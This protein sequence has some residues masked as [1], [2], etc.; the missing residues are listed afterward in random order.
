MMEDRKQALSMARMYRLCPPPG[1]EGDAAN[2]D[3]LKRHI[4]ICPYC[5]DL[6]EEDL[7]PWNDLAAAIGDLFFSDHPSGPVVAGR[8]YYLKKALGR[9]RGG[10]YYTP[11]MVMVIDASPQVSE[12]ILVAQIYHD[13]VLAGPGDL[14]LAEKQGIEG[15]LFVEP[16]NIYTLRLSD[17][18]QEV[19][20]VGQDVVQAV[21]DMDENPDAPP[22]WAPVLAPFEQQDVRSYFREMEIEVGYTFSAPAVADLVQ[23]LEQKAPGLAYDDTNSLAADLQAC[24]AGIRWAEEVRTP[25]EMLL[26]MELPPEAVPLAAAD[27]SPQEPGGWAPETL[28]ANIIYLESGRVRK[29]LA[30]ECQVAAKDES[31]GMVRIS[32]KISGLPQD[33]ASM[34]LFCML[35]DGQGCLRAPSKTEWNIDSGWFLAEF[36]DCKSPVRDFFATIT[37]N[38]V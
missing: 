25:E 31:A 34:H 17:L 2:N 23:K 14:V 3:E 11:P 12:E 27:F 29:I 30:A 28:V 19:G 21:W 6:Q 9:W 13:I 15:S 8:L 4:Q 36:A 10:Y 33:A 5:Q 35:R 22:S 20:S 26:T 18:G 38:G 37:V 7:G 16:W 24:H 32:G 1:V